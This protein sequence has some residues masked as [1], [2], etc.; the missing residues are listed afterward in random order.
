SLVA[1]NSPYFLAGAKLSYM[2]TTNW[3]LA[4]IITNGWQ[5]IRRIP[6]NSLPSFGTQVNY[7]QENYT[8]N[9][10]TFIG[11]DD[12]DATRRMR[13][14]NNLYAVISISE[15]LDL[16]AGFDIGVQQKTKGS[17][18]VDV[19]YGP[20]AIARYT[21]NPEWAVAARV[22]YYADEHGVIIP[23]PSP[24]GFK[25]TGTSINI[26]Y[27]PFRNIAC[28]LEG[29]WFRA[30]DQIFEKSDGLTRNNVF[31]VASLAI[32]ING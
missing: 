16:T 11:T 8:L 17:S 21:F 6:G 18:S 25:T 3:T 32:S 26:D 9:W 13:Y 20:T 14:F 31:L 5:R 23:V 12:P 22:E 27:T 4:A 7:S 1:E 28:R 19:W 15:A 30:S 10:S 29:R 2:P 24:E